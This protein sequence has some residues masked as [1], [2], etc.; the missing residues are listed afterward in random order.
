[1]V[2]DASGAGEGAKCICSG[3]PVERHCL[4]SGPANNRKR[5]FC[6]VLWRT[7]ASGCFTSLGQIRQSDIRGET[8][9]GLVVSKSKH[10]TNTIFLTPVHET[11]IETT[12]VVIM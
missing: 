2:G 1:M 4:M 8:R 7:Q 12:K 3:V 10:K 11:V 9:Q 5:K 6:Q